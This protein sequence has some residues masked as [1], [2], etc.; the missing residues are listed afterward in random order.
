MD[1]FYV[2]RTGSVFVLTKLG[3]RWYLAGDPI[4]TDSQMLWPVG[5]SAN[6]KKISSYIRKHLGLIELR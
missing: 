3:D 1:H 4:F 2:S 6:F 5:V